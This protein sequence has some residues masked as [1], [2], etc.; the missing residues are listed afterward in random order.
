MSVL[1]TWKTL[2]SKS[3]TAAI[4]MVVFFVVAMAVYFG[5]CIYVLILNKTITEFL[6]GKYVT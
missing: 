2:M 6:F 3:V 5:K 4:F 1:R